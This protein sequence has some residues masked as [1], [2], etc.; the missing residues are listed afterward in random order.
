MGWTDGGMHGSYQINDTPPTWPIDVSKKARLPPI[1]LQS[2]SC[3]A[4]RGNIDHDSTRSP[5]EPVVLKA[6]KGRMICG[7]TCIVGH[8]WVDGDIATQTLGEDGGSEDRWSVAR[9]W[10][11]ACPTLSLVSLGLPE[12]GSCGTPA[13]AR[14]SGAPIDHRVN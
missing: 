2:S 1:A 7:V 5:C 9:E 14:V 13:R 3:Q 6:V 10:N 12:G 8:Q 11:G 4:C